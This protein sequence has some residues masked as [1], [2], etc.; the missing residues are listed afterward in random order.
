MIF[1]FLSALLGI[2][3]LL[4]GSTIAGPVRQEKD[5]HFKS[6]LNHNDCPV[7]RGTKYSVLAKTFGVLCG[8]DTKARGHHWGPYYHLD[9]SECIEKCAEKPGCSVATYTR[10]FYLNKSASGK[11]YVWVNRPNDM[12]AIKLNDK[13]HKGDKSEHGGKETE[14]GGG[15]DAHTGQNQHTHIGQQNEH[16]H[17]GSKNEHTQT[18]HNDGHKKGG[19]STHKG[20]NHDEK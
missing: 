8:W 13:S 16:T 3:V 10:T 14:L 6:W 17:T 20:Q 7:A 4:A 1:S 12:T 15:K 11:G 18:G 9:F 5:S 2:L 19:K